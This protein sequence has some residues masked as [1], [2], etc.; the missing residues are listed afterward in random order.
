MVVVYDACVLYP[1]A[2]RDLLIRIG[3]AGLVNARWTDTI[4]DECFRAIHRE[5]PEVPDAALARTRRLMCGAVR[6]CL[7]DGYEDLVEGLTLPDPND[8]HVFAAAIRAGAQTIVTRNLKDFPADRLAPFGVQAQD[9]DE[10][11]LGLIG[12]QGSAVL[13]IIVE[14]AADL[15]SPPQTVEDVLRT[16][17]AN[18]LTRSV[19]EIS[20][21]LAGG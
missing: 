5:R 12:Q 7:V 11:V 9:P 4:L 13:R 18:G 15:R 17:E 20:A 1:A 16:L 2:L 21:Q 6:D 14:Q 8:R 10:F 19:A 3:H